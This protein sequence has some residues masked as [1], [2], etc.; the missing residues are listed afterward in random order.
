[1]FYLQFWQLCLHV[2]CVLR[3][4]SGPLCTW[5]KAT[6]SLARVSRGPCP[7]GAPGRKRGWLTRVLQGPRGQGSWQHWS[8]TTVNL[9]LSTLTRPSSDFSY[10]EW[11]WRCHRCFWDPA[12]GK[13]GQ[14]SIWF[15]LW[16][17]VRGPLTST[18]CVG[19]GMT[20]RSTAPAQ[21]YKCA[22]DAGTGSLHG[23]EDMGGA[24]PPPLSTPTATLFLPFS[25]R[26]CSHF[27]S[28]T[29]HF[30]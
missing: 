3:E 6:R 9:S 18:C 22:L 8:Q 27:T 19:V 7:L 11:G 15:G 25:S 20:S 26:F 1:M 30:S 13:L 17:C 4:N 23:R 2:V 24:C 16:I 28:L 14:G 12:Q 10:V 21:M 29:S 5:C